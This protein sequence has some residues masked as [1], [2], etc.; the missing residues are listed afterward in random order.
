MLNLI[1]F[2]LETFEL[3]FFQTN[4]HKIFIIHVSFDYGTHEFYFNGY[5]IANLHFKAQNFLFLVATAC[6]SP[7]KCLG[8]CEGNYTVES[9]RLC[10]EEQCCCPSNNTKS[11]FSY[12]FIVTPT[13]DY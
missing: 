12:F 8:S 11:N 6:D 7:C 3:L 10:E 4:Q 2:Y 5:V 13:F 1:G 9:E